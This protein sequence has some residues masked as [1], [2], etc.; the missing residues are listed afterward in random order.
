MGSISD[1]LELELLDHVFGVAYSVP[2][3][4]YIALSTADPLDTGAGISEPSGNGYARKVHN[5]WDAAAAR[6]TENTGVITF[7][8]ASGA[9][10]LITHYAIFDAITGGNFLGHGSLAV[11]KDVVDGNT[12]SIADGEIEVSFNTGA[13]STYL[14][15][16]LL[17]HVFKV[18]PYTQP[19]IHVAL[20][21]ANPT[22][23]GSGLAEPT[24]GY[25]RKAHATWDVA[26]AGAT[27]NTGAITFATPSGTWGLITHCAIMDALTSGNMLWY[28]T[29][30]PN[31]TPD[32]GDTVEYAD[33][34]LDVSLS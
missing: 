26:A 18:A 21:T 4:I 8:Q 22:D 17:D 33:G 24:N 14:A 31:Q 29:A 16:A 1:Y 5:S 9:W 6:L 25:A 3:N 27:E 10:G 23:D 30:T 34:D 2:A 32:A 11:S 19:T 7:A 20:S 15:N 28:G 12:P 13:I